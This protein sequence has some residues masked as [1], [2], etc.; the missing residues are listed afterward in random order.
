MVTRETRPSLESLN[1]EKAWCFVAVEFGYY[2][3]GFDTLLAAMR[4]D[5]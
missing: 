5:R 3:Q 2:V 1:E 4:L